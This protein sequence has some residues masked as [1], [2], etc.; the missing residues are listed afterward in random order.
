[1]LAS[2]V[3]TIIIII[4]IYSLEVLTSVYAD[5]LSLEIE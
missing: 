3:P 2:P 1:M 4:I 5:G